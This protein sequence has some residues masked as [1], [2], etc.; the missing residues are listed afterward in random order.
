MSFKVP[1]ILFLFS[2]FCCSKEMHENKYHKQSDIFHDNKK[3]SSVPA[4]CRH[5]IYYL[6]AIYRIASSS[7]IPH[8]HLV[9]MLLEKFKLYACAQN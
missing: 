3:Q 1:V 8:L 4:I 6:K 5:G 9:F 7:H 2:M